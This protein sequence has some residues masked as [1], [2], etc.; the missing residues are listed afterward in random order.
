M[1]ALSFN[2]ME[3][4]ALG[5]MM[6]ISLGASATAMS[7]LLGS[8]VHITTP[9]VKILT[10]DQFE[11][12]KLEPAVGVEIAYVEGLEGSNIMMF[13]RNDVRIIVGTLLGEEVPDDKFE[14]DEINRSAIC[15][16]MN[17]M[18]GASA[19]ALS[20][21]LKFTVNIS[22]PVSFEITDAESFKNKYF[23]EAIPMVV[24]SFILEIEGKL[25]SEFLNIMPEKLA[26]RLLEPFEISLEEAAE[27]QTENK[28]S[29]S[30]TE[31]AAEKVIEEAAEKEKPQ[32]E[33]E[34]APSPQPVPTPQP[35]PASQPVYTQMPAG[36]AAGISTDMNP[37]ILQLLNQ[38]QQSQVQMM[39]LMQ[40]MEKREQD[41]KKESREP[42]LIRQA[43]AP[44]LEASGIEKGEE[45]ANQEMLMK[46]PLEISVEIGRTKKL[47]K[48]ILEFTQGSLVVLDK[49]AGE[50]ADLYVNGQCVAR[51][52]IVVVED[53]FG[54]RITDIV[55]R[56]INPESL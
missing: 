50:Q 16:V 52:D 4:D 25:K 3:I 17:Q 28:E 1:G 34:P 33:P 48:D 35:A 10:R 29:G 42:A 14:L 24:I 13:S 9:K 11:F 37:A 31:E 8:T 22:T 53:N 49:M 41:E 39:Q 27:I 20:E 44:D 56:D 12:K 15:E 5:E 51:G 45:S 30:K 40:D 18:M 54:I 23:P 26:K 43:K 19:T 21:F 46:V 6:N 47:V 2:E 36:M 7:T 32:P 38:M 55:T